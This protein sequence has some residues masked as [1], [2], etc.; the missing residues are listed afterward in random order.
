MVEYRRHPLKKFEKRFSSSVYEITSFLSLTHHTLWPVV[1]IF[2]PPPP[3]P[4][5][6]RHENTDIVGE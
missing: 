5:P 6:P 2:P 3:S 1:D 4:P